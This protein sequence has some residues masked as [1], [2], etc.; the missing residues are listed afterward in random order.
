MSRGKS[1]S[2][3]GSAVSSSLRNR[4]RNSSFSTGSMCERRSEEH[5]SELQSRQY[6]VCR[7]LLEKKTK[8]EDESAQRLAQ[9]LLLVGALL[10]LIVG[11]NAA[12]YQAVRYLFHVN[13]QVSY[14]SQRIRSLRLFL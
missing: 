6:L 7:L 11:D 9:A 1:R 4:P 3:S 2:M 5:T 14:T 13:S 8:L 12:F 10:H